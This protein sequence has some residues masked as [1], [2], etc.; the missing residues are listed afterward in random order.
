MSNESDSRRILALTAAPTGSFCEALAAAYRDGAQSA[1][2]DVRSIDLGRLAFDPV[3]RQGYREIQALESDLLAAQES[4]RWA[5]H[6]VFAYPLWWGTMPALLK[7]FIE[8]VFLPGFA[9]QYR[10]DS[11]LWDRL[12]SGRSAQLIVT[13][14]TPPWFFHLIYRRAGHRVMK[15]NI[16][17]FCGIWPVRVLDVGPVKTAN[18]HKRRQWLER[19][20]EA[21]R[22]A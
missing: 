3:L 18:E 9:F 17:E 4:I 8:R 21:G 5:Q 15:S 2:H 11:V 16:L 6:L 13:M 10:P 12:L 20:R 7:G 1:G 14:D 22:R 19:A